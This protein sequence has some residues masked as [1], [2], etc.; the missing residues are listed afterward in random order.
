MKNLALVIL[1]SFSVLPIFSQT[2]GTLS[3]AQDLEIYKLSERVYIHRTFQTVKGFGRFTSNGMV[4]VKDGQ[5]VIF[6]T[7]PNVPYTDS[8]IKWIQDSL[9]AQI[10]GVVV[11]HFH[12]D[13][14]GGLEAVHKLGIPS[15]AS[16]WTQY[17][18][19]KDSAIVPTK[20]FNRKK[21]LS[22][23]GKKIILEFL[24]GAHT[25]DNI[26]AYIPSEKVLFGGCMIKS[27]WSN[28]GNTA[29]A[30]MF[31]WPET[32]KEVRRK[33]NDAEYVIPGHGKHGGLEL[34]DYTIKLF[35]R[36]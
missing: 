26:I 6:D 31:M 4:F 16:S 7:P 22:V 2:R 27:L 30:N 1:L 24:G 33:Y 36:N 17:L 25:D 28:Q 21:T 19:S 20:G 13:C 23:G 29:N 12:V 35:S 15:Y 18:A 11:N 10:V 34:L 5:C 32:V 14:L 3:L 8:L 9:Q